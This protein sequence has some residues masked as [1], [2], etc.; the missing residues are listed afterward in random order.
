MTAKPK[1]FTKLALARELK[2][3][4]TTVQKYLGQDGAPKADKEGRYDKA[5][6]ADF[7][8]K[9]GSA[10][11]EGSEMRNLRA[12]KLRAETEQLEAELAARRGETITK[13]EI[14]PAIAAFN[15]ELT[16]NLR[17][18]FELELPGRYKGKG[19]VECQQMNAAAIDWIL[20]RL[21][22]GQWALGIDGGPR[23]TT[24]GE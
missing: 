10:N 11:V 16:A 13:S 4:R 24:T 15:V 8:A 5:A 14:A 1:T 23:S 3:S 18:K 20:E 6:V 22:A 17:Q 19:M 21:K 2:L 9:Q 12:R 7:I